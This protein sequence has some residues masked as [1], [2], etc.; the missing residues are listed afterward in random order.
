M[1]RDFIANVSHELKTPLA[2]LAA[3]AE[4]LA[5]SVAGDPAAAGLAA[6]L[7][8]EAERLARLVGD[9]L[10]LSGRGTARTEP[11]RSARSGRWPGRWSPSPQEGG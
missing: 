9:I 3:L 4:A 11:V 1:W 5:G 10:D 7:R 6:R 8:H 2:A